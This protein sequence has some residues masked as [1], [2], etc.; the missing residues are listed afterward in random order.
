MAEQAMESV[1]LM[2]PPEHRDSFRLGLL[3]ELEFDG[4]WI[5]DQAAEAGRHFVPRPP[6]EKPAEPLDPFDCIEGPIRE[7]QHDADVLRQL[8]AGDGTE[9]E[10]D[11]V[12]LKH[13]LEAT[14]RLLAEHLAN[15]EFGDESTREEMA[16]CFWAATEAEQLE[17]AV[18]AVLEKRRLEE[19]DPD[20]GES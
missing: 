11:P 1:K 7:L 20:G 8:E 15:V 9:I 12:A 13:T 14:A 10:A 3:H 4:R 17:K 5:K 6:W 19:A 2:V 16:S 18:K